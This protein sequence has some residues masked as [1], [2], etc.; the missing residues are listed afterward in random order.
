MSE[1][2]LMMLSSFVGI[3]SLNPTHTY[4]SFVLLLWV[5]SPLL[6]LLYVSYFCCHFPHLYGNIEQHFSI[7]IRCSLMIFRVIFKF[8][9]WPLYRSFFIVCFFI[10]ILIWS[11][12]YLLILVCVYSSFGSNQ[13]L[14]FHSLFPFCMQKIWLHNSF[15]LVTIF[16][17][18]DNWRC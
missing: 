18:H 7:H 14:S 9:T 2:F 15:S 6:F 12:I 17:I 16:R 8:I 1:C 10:C 3:C 11:S 13:V 4:S 5:A